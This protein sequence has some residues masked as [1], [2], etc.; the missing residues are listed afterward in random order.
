MGTNHQPGQHWPLRSQDL[1]RRPAQVPARS[2][3][4]V[5]GTVIAVMLAVGGLVVVG[6]AVV[7]AVALS[8]MGGK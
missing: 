3:W 4:A 5:I 8:H 2:V 1:D 7:A 6:F